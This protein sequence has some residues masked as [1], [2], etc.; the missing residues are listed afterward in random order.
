MAYNL[1]YKTYLK[2][3]DFLDYEYTTP[4]LS[5]TLNELRTDIGNNIIS[6]LPIEIKVNKSKILNKNI[7]NEIT[8][9]NFKIL[10]YYDKCEIYDEI[11][12][13]MIGPEIRHLWDQKP[14]KQVV[15]VSYKSDRFY[16]ILEWERDL[17]TKN[18]EWQVSNINNIL[19]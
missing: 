11:S 10:G 3:N 19:R 16:D 18:P 4:K 7:K 2:K 13:G 1:I 12:I 15:N 17:T 8:T 6:K 9:N 14:V 5:I